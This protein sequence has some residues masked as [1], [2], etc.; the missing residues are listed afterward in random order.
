MSVLLM[1]R[2]KAAGRIRRVLGPIGRRVTIQGGGINHSGGGARS[3]TCIVMHYCSIEHQSCSSGAAAA[4]A[5][6][7]R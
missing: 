5:E 7:T 2:S 4:E 3:T 1:E 6:W